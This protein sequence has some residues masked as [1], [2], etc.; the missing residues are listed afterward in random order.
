M[1]IDASNGAVLYNGTVQPQSVL[2][3]GANNDSHEDGDD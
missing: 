3:A 2:A 1:Y